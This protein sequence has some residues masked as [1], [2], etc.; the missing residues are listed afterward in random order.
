MSDTEPKPRIRQK[1]RKNTDPTVGPPAKSSRLVPPTAEVTP[2]VNGSSDFSKLNGKSYFD[3]G[4]SGCFGIEQPVTD[5]S[6]ETFK[7]WSVL[8]MNKTSSIAV[9]NAGCGGAQSTGPSSRTTTQLI[10]SELSG[11]SPDSSL[12]GL[13]NVR[14]FIHTSKSQSSERLESTSSEKC[15]SEDKKKELSTSRTELGDTNTD[16]ELLLALDEDDDC[17]CM[18]L[19]TEEDIL[20]QTDD[21]MNYT[22]S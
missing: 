2:Q 11:K 15:V 17:I 21:I 7:S 13:W 14:H 12:N 8:P 9:S 1:K 6:E 16:E 22:F 3:S 18:T 4:N 20:L 5:I 19:D 10:T